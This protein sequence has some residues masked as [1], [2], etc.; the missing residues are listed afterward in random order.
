LVLEI[1]AAS[2]A[3]GAASEKGV[4]ILIPGAVKAAGE[5]QIV[6]LQLLLSLAEVGPLIALD[7]CPTREMDELQAEQWPQKDRIRA[8]YPIAKPLDPRQPRPHRRDDV[9][10]IGLAGDVGHR[11]LSQ[12]C[13]HG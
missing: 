8:A 4:E 5:Q 2:V 9:H 12:P 13:W 7:D 10:D 6:V 1:Q 3:T 11:L